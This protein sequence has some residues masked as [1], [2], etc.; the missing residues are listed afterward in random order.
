MLVLAGPGSG[1]TYVITRRIRHLIEKGGIEP[2]EILV[3]TFTKAAALEMKERFEKLCEGKFYPVNFGTFHAVFYHILS[4]TYHYSFQ[5]IITQQK[6]KEYMQIVLNSLPLEL[7]EIDGLEGELLSEISYLKNS[8][9]QAENYKS[10]WFEPKDFARIYDCYQE[11]LKKSRLLDFD[12]MVADCLELFRKRE[13]ILRKWQDQ[14]RYILVDEFQDINPMQ[15]QVVRMLAEPE[16]NLFVVGDDDQSIYSFRG[17]SPSIMLGFERD[18]PEAK[19]VCLSQNF[20]SRPEIL[21]KAGLLIGKN[22]ERF[23]KKIEPGREEGEEKSF[24]IYPFETA[25]KQCSF[26]AGKISEMCGLSASEE[27]QKVTSQIWKPEEIA[28]IYRTNSDASMLAEKLTQEG[29][30]FFMRERLKSIYGH[31]VCQDLLAYLEFALENR[32]RKAFLRIMNRPVRYIARNALNSDMVSIPE[33]QRFYRDRPYMVPVLDRLQKDLTMIVNMDLYAAVNY[34]RKGIGYEAWMKKEAVHKRAEVSEWMQAADYF[35]NT[36]RRFSSVEDLKDYI[37]EFEERL[38]NAG[39][40]EK[41][42]EGKVQLL[43]MHASKG[44]EFPVVFLPDCNEGKTPHRKS[45]SGPQLEEERR[46]F[47]VGM[48]RAKEKLILTWV[49]GTGEN[50]GFPS[51]FLGEM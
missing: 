23:A 2:S 36:V 29:I 20:R 40:N 28:V 45:L 32:S 35:Q 3:I 1:K 8:G 17:A 33:L 6:K 13:D 47:Y 50:P 51:R 4:C 25:E 7:P 22:K 39:S 16:N 44:L 31:P 11:M 37:E 5:N 18:Y 10:A 12:D 34:I 30:P 48:T 21:E 42:K 9:I 24:F 19:K 15:Y 26:L 46:M 38:L 27:R 49:K 41:E 14:F 43:T